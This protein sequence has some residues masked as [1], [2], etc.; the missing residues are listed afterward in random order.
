MVG[1]AALKEK[2]WGEYRDAVVK[3]LVTLESEGWTV[4]FTDGPAKQVKGWWQAGYGV[5]FGESSPRNCSL[6]VP[7]AERQ[8]VSR[9]ELRGVLY[10]LQSRVRDERLVVVL[11]SE[12]VYKGI[13]EWS[14]KWRRHGW[15]VRNREVGHRDPW[16]L[17]WNLR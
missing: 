14:P 4:A 10:A 16:Q 13:M 3:R 12:Y 9:G 6:P 15:R 2:K 7:I 17:I 1:A 11:G 5:W 8:S